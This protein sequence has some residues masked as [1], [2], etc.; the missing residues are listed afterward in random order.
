MILKRIHRF[1]NRG[2]IILS[3]IL[4]QSGCKQKDEKGEYDHTTE[5]CKS[6]YAEAYRT[7]GSGAFGG[8]II[9]NYLT[10]SVDF[11]VFVGTFDNYDKHFSYECSSDTLRIYSLYKSGIDSMSRITKTDFYT[12][13][14]LK[15]LQ[16][17]SNSEIVILK[18]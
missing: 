11:R 13:S 5:V 9:A 17:Y 15:Q 2:C 16:N 4:L 8:D 6:L 7:F 10:D 1:S 14:E 3:L 18:K 12:I